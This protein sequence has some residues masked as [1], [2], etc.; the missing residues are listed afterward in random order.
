VAT[1][2]FSPVAGSYTSAQTVTLS[3]ATA[4]AAIYYTTNGT[5]PTTTSTL[6][7]GAITV[8][9][10]ETIEAIAVAS[11]YANSAVGTAV[12][13]IT[14]SFSLSIASPAITVL[15]GLKGTVPVVVTPTGGFSSAITFTCSGLSAIDTCS[16]SPA[17]VT[18]SGSAV[19]ETVTV[20][21]PLQVAAVHH[22]KPLTYVPQF[23]AM[24][25]I[26][27]GS[28]KM[29]RRVRGLVMFS[30]IALC[31]LMML[32]GCGVSAPTVAADTSQTTTVTVT[33]TAGT[34]TSSATFTLTVP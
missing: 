16:F 4:G 1:P 24:L 20:T 25:F 14:P 12:F 30:A 31:G 7:A 11:G 33:G 15:A 2:T 5:T 6:Y 8:N 28:W 18:P 23:A 22:N 3:D 26:L 29:R 9:S 19:T 17:T 32:T 13:T 21:V 34:L 27:C 10:T